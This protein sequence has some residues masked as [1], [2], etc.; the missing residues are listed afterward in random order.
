MSTQNVPAT[1]QKLKFKERKVNMWRLTKL[2]RFLLVLDEA[3]AVGKLQ[4]F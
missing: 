3:K 4:Q 2:T 1:L